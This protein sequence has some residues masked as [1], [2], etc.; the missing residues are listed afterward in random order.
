VSFDPG[1][2]YSSRGQD[3]LKPLLACS[4]ILFVTQEELHALTGEPESERAASEIIRMG[5]ETV[6]LKMG[7]QGL[8]A[9]QEDRSFSCRGVAPRRI[10]DRTGAGDVAAAGFLAGMI[11]GLPVEASLELAAASA[12]RSIEGYGRSMYP[13]RDFFSELTSKWRDSV[14]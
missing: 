5:V 11:E 10:S 9:F 4:K 12:S 14:E 2:I 6:V 7:A 13:D 3:A 8:M 1:A